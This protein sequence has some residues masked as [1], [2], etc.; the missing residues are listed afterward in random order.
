MSSS[1]G[2]HYEQTANLKHGDVL[3]GQPGAV[4]D[5]RDVT[6]WAVQPNSA[7]NV[8]VRGLEIR[9]YNPDDQYAPITASN[10]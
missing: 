5:G 2:V 1:Q 10:L 7:N 3:I 6:D 8:T 9:N 4:M